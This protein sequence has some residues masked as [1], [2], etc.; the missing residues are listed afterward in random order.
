MRPVVLQVFDYS[1][2][3]IERAGVHIM[4]RATYEGMAHHF[5]TATDAIANLMNRTPK[6]GLLSDVAGR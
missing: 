2:D 5:P 3:G 6:A 4:G 1:L